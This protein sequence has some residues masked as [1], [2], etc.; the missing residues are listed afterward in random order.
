MIKNKEIPDPLS[1][2]KEHCNK[3]LFIEDDKGL[4][5]SLSIVLL[6]ET[7][8]FNTLLRTMKNSLENLK[9]AIEGTALMSD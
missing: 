1:T 5:P 7:A 8:R 9:S 2:N 4:L 3:E 6:Q